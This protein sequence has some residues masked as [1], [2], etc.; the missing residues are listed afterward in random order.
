MGQCSCPTNATDGSWTIA[1]ASSAS[2]TGRRELTDAYEPTAWYAATPAAAPSSG[3]RASTG[4]MAT[5]AAA[6]PGS[7]IRASTGTGSMEIHGTAP[8][9]PCNASTKRARSAIWPAISYSASTWLAE[10]AK[11]HAAWDAKRCQHGPT[12][13][14]I[15]DA[16]DPISW[17]HLRLAPQ[18]NQGVQRVHC[19]GWNDTWLQTFGHP[20]PRPRTERELQLATRIGS[21]QAVKNS[22]DL[23]QHAQHEN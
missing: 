7:G 3:T 13:P 5:P 8:A 16:A 23:A 14:W 4:T 12:L 1:S 22:V 17:R 6:A 18:Q 10:H 21:R 20:H 15:N 19:M 2:A 9:F 11:L